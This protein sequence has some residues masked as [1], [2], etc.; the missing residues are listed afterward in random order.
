MSSS[1]IPPILRPDYTW[2]RPMGPIS[3]TTPPVPHIPSRPIRLAWGLLHKALYHVSKW[4]CAW[5]GI[6]SYYNV[7]ELPFGLVMKWTNRISL[8]EVAGMQMARA[9]G[10]PVP[11]LI[12]CGE[13]VNDPVNRRFSLL[14]TRLPG[15]DLDNSRDEFEP[16][17]ELPWLEEL[18][19]CVRAMRSWTPPDPRAICS[20]IGAEI[21]STRV[22]SHVMGPFPSDKELYD[23]LFGP[24]SSHAFESKAEY[25]D[26]Y[27]HAPKLRQFP[28]RITFTHGGFKAHNIMIDDEGHLSGFMDWES[29]GWYPEYWEF[30]T[31][32]RFGGGSWWYQVAGWMGGNKYLEELA[33]DKALDLLTVDSYIAF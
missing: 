16:D 3:T 29:A 27:T 21:Y 7:F 2:P 14:M 6:H 9:A 17:D 19:T 13:H 30:T 18:A 15:F 31:A 24:A 23:F 5:F 10:M 22:P 4:Y 26:T 32:M 20:P 11:K 28:A 33:A 1:F 25:D 8:A 12:S